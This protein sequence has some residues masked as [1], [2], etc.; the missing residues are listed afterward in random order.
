MT[1]Q[2]RQQWGRSALAGSG[3]VGLVGV[4][5]GV[6][7]LS[8]A[9]SSIFAACSAVGRS[10]GLCAQNRV[11]I[12][13]RSGAKSG[14]QFVLAPETTP[15]MYF[16]IPSSMEC[17]DSDTTTTIMQLCSTSYS[18]T[19]NENMSTFSVYDSWFRIS[20][21]MYILEPFKWGLSVEE[22]DLQTLDPLRPE[23][24]FSAPL[25]LV[26]SRAASVSLDGD[27]S[28]CRVTVHRIRLADPKSPSLAT[29]F[30]SSHCVRKML[31]GLTSLWTTGGVQ[32][33]R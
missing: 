21:A 11:I 23:A 28:E 24:V 29:T 3:A 17:S 22:V 14:R 6:S 2:P 1:L 26:L 5:R 12:S 31:S 33:C 18:V 20:G 8:S 19:P 25:P 9:A 16:R 15:L 27:F 30:P 10:S 32:L 4:E 13:H 7:R